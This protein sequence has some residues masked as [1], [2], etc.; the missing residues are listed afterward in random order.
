MGA[1]LVF[2]DEFRL[3]VGASEFEGVNEEVYQV[4]YGELGRLEAYCESLGVPRDSWPNFIDLDG[5]PDL[6][7]LDDIRTK[8]A[9]LRDALQAL[10]D[11]AIAKDQNLIDVV[12]EVRRGKLLFITH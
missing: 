12:R 5:L 3:P 4:G 9:K 1:Y 7:S 2:A 8:N 6:V 11:E 10:S